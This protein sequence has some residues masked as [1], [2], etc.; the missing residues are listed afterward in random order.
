M[1]EGRYR[2][3]L[4]LVQVVVAV[5]GGEEIAVLDPIEGF[6]HGP[7][8][9]VLADP[10]V[11]VVMHAGRQDVA[12]LRRA[13]GVAPANVFDTQIAAAFAGLGAQRGYGD[14]LEQLVGVRL[15][16]GES[17]TRWDRRPLTPEQLEYA[18]QDVEQLLEMSAELERRLEKSGRLEWAR[19][20]CRPLEEANDE[21]EPEDAF[22][23][24]PRVN[25]L[26]PREIAVARE[27][28]AWRE[29][30]AQDE[31]K[32]LSSIVADHVLVEVAKR[33][34]SDRAELEHVRGVHG[35]TLKRRGREM[36]A[37][38]QAG[39]EAEP[40]ELERDREP[41]LDKRDVPAVALS[42][43]L[44]RARTTE[45]NLA[46]ELVAT[47]ADLTRIVSAVRRG[48]PEPSVRT[49]QGW[50]REM[51]GE[52]LLELLQGRLNLGLGDNGLRVERAG[53]RSPA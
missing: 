51:V 12:I 9:E 16:K 36:L 23:R 39:L 26:R 24:L 37:A 40:V 27:L 32:P 6:D 14:L 30:A 17:F 52:Q 10:A 43:A 48:A 31:D 44:V 38:V 3:L 2:P 45:E 19:E 1:T 42:E 41:P 22:L 50:R 49:L 29:R 28:A 21:R 25:R 4:S 7:L 8:A 46:Y 47:R 5:D 18:R 15:K 13:W 34:P 33:K 11:E 35:G 20:E 53:E